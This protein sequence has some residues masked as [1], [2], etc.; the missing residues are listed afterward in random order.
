MVALFLGHSQILS[1][2][3]GD[4]IWEWLGY[5]VVVFEAQDYYQKYRLMCLVFISDLVDSDSADL[6]LY[7]HHLATSHF[8]HLDIS[9]YRTTLKRTAVERHAGCH[10]DE[11]VLFQ[12]EELSQDQGEDRL[13]KRCCFCGQKIE[14]LSRDKPGSEKLRVTEKG[15]GMEVLRRGCVCGEA[16]SELEVRLVR[17]WESGSEEGGG[18]DDSGGKQVSVQSLLLFH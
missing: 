5:C 18:D 1:C 8:Q 2:S 13:V 11:T 4:K 9:K 3:R 17:G 16:R 12:A 15:R 6:C 10:D 14:P 7:C